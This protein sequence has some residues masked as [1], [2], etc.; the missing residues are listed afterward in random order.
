MSAEIIDPLLQSSGAH[1][2]S[3]RSIFR[4]TLG[5]RSV[6]ETLTGALVYLA[7]QRKDTWYLS[8]WACYT[9]SAL[10]NCC[11]IQKYEASLL[12]WVPDVHDQTVFLHSTGLPFIRSSF[13]FLI[14]YQISYIARLWKHCISFSTCAFTLQVY[15]LFSHH[16]D[17]DA[18]HGMLEWE[19]KRALF[20]WSSKMFFDWKEFSC[21][22]HTVHVITG[23]IG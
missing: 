8:N 15:M 22:E 10:T 4:E 2:L 18:F 11:L 23:E 1:D 16:L 21:G 3:Y 12:I 19:R 14:S 9:G 6:W 20:L 7:M 17:I 5:K 13:S